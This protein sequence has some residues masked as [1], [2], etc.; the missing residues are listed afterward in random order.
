M[1][2]T[3]SKTTS[4]GEQKWVLNPDT[5]HWIMKGGLT[6]ESIAKSRKQLQ[7]LGYESGDEQEEESDSSSD[8]G[9]EESE[10]QDYYDF[11]E[12][13]AV[14][15]AEN[16]IHVDLHGE[17]LE[18][19]PSHFPDSV[20]TID[21]SDNKLTALPETLAQNKNLKKIDCSYN[22]IE[23]LPKHLPPNLKYFKA[24]ENQ[25]RKLPRTLPADLVYLDVTDN[26]ITSL[27][28]NTLPK[29][30]AVFKCGHNKIQTLPEK[31]PASIVE[32][33]FTGNPIEFIPRPLLPKARTVF[34]FGTPEE[35]KRLIQKSVS[36][37]IM[38]E[39]LPLEIAETLAKYV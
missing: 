4:R 35:T 1:S 9:D 39:K 13:K 21:C 11:S 31:F 32:A 2:K 5:N 17:G 27:P 24:I 22:Y 29:N 33:D 26:L 18:E 23:R 10:E 28:P 12:E 6:D 15:T 20:E 3:P 38:S 30:L 36:I 34:T 19:M 7:L 16:P 14:G 25:I 8:S 37:A